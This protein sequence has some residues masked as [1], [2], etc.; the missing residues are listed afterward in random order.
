MTL[1]NFVDGLAFSRT[2]KTCLLACE[3]HESKRPAV[4]G[5][6]CNARPLAGNNHVNIT[7]LLQD[8]GEF[9]RRVWIF[10]GQA[11]HVCWLASGTD[12]SGRQWL[13]IFA[14]LAHWQETIM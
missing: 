9:F 2:S 6:L 8:A 13:G 11:K 14:T 1:G 5:H 10:S 3:R 4:V 12:R 7:Q